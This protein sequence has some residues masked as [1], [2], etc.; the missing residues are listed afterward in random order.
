MPIIEILCQFHCLFYKEHNEYGFSSSL[1]RSFFFLFF[2][3]YSKATHLLP[4]TYGTQ[5]WECLREEKGDRESPPL[6]KKNTCC[7][8]HLNFEQQTFQILDEIWVNQ[9]LLD[10][11]FGDF[12]P[13]ISRETMTRNKHMIN[14]H[15]RHKVTKAMRLFKRCHLFVP[16]IYKLLLH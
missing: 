11:S 16:S 8:Q 9:V 10:A 7:L 12:T 14:N 6:Q 5:K 15:I 13:L 3:C 4:H 1:F 2:L